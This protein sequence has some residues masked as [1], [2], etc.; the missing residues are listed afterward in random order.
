[1]SDRRCSPRVALIGG[2]FWLGVVEHL[3]GRAGIVVAPVAGKPRW[4]GL[5][6]ILSRAFLRAKVIHVV[7]GGHLIVSIAARL[8]GKTLVWHWIGSDVV[9]F[10]RHRG[11]AGWLR[12]RLARQS[13][14]VHLADSPELADELEQLGIAAQVCR[15]L[16]RSIE[17]EVLPLPDRFRVLSYWTDERRAFY[18]GDLI[19]K[20]AGEI[21]D[22]EFLIAGADGED[23][24]RSPNVTFLGM[25]ENLDDVYARVSVFLRLPEHDSLSAMVLE[26]LARGRYV[27]YNKAF[28]HCRQA[29]TMPEIRSALQ[30]FRGLAEPNRAGAAFVKERFSLQRE[31][32]SLRRVYHQLPRT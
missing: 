28:P 2:D 11:I 21:D 24:G 19:L 27:I 25:R 26:A 18:G 15:L 29:D 7:W 3:F 9:A 20:L 4:F 14:Q 30:E 23:T 22:I 13:V 32:D 6:W 8:L 16:P 12:K 10:R 1:M 17:A 5:S 31:A